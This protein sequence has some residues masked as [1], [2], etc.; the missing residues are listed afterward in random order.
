MTAKTIDEVISQ[1]DG[2]I[3]RAKRE[4][5]RVGY[6]SALYRKVTI[7][8]KE[9]IEAGIFDD[10][11]RME[12]LDVIFANRYLEAI[13]NYWDGKPVSEA[14]QVSFEAS[15]S[16]SVTV[17]QHLLLGMNAHINLDLG[18]AAAQ[19]SPGAALAGLQDDFN[20]INSV[21]ASLVNGVNE[22]LTEVWPTLR[23]LDKLAGRLDDVLIN[24]SMEKARDHAWAFAKSLAPLPKE[25]QN[26]KIYDADQ[27]A[28]GFA[29]V[30]WKP[31][32]VIGIANAVISLTERGTVAEKIE[33]LC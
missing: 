9:G 24:F 18:I 21:L 22:E 2:V 31:G 12:K 5:S 30:V 11:P 33:L 20:K 15:N 1:L 13:Q 3:E 10:G 32:K 14:W 23:F 25:K 7:K 28:G 6:F 26:S 8:V 17:L 16:W 4:K 27:W 19:T 29:K